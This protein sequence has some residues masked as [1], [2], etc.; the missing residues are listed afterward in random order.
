MKLNY[1]D[2]FQ[3]WLLPHLTEHEN[4]FIF[5]QGRSTSHFRWSVGELLN[6]TLPKCWIGE[7]KLQIKW[8][9]RSPDLKPSSF[10]EAMQRKGL[11]AKSI[12]DH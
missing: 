12:A 2:M 9:L 11:C 8:P 4:M 10:C 1:L 3:N 7:E 5:Q 6:A